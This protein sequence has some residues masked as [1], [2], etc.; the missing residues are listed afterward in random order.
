MFC[1]LCSGIHV[2]AGRSFDRLHYNLAANFSHHALPWRCAHYCVDGI[3]IPLR[4]HLD[5]VGLYSCLLRVYTLVLMD[6][7]VRI[8]RSTV[9]VVGYHE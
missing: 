8:L 7:V 2:E 1:V 5:A 6:F 4:I 3:S 9:G